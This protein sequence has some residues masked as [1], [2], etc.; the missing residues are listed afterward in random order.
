MNEIFFKELK[1]LRQ[2]MDDAFN[3]FLSAPKLLP[4]LVP[5]K[6][7]ELF[8][9]PLAEVVEREKDVLVSAKMPGLRKEDIAINFKEGMLE[10][11]GER[12]IEG[13]LKQEKT[14]HS[15]ISLP[16]KVKVDNAD[17]KYENG[18]LTVALPKV[19]PGL[20]KLGYKLKKR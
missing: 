10:L 7:V 12:K 11:S 3:R 8:Q 5:G 15:L 13:Y 9:H 4:K 19:H 20:K 16:T 18:I 6:G 14:Y 2:E 1:R 17:L